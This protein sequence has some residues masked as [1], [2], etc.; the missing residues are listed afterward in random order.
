MVKKFFFIGF[1]FFQI[2]TINYALMTLKVKFFFSSMKIKN[3]SGPIPHDANLAAKGI[4]GLDAFSY[5]CTLNK[6]QSGKKKN[7]F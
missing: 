1:F 4:L 3:I 6:N 2:L 7:Y 5:L